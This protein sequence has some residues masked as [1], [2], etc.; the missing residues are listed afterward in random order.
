MYYKQGGFCGRRQNINKGGAGGD[1]VRWANV[2]NTKKVKL[3]NW[4]A[5][6]KRPGKKEE[7]S[8]T[9]SL[10]AYDFK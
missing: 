5:Y 6:S 3:I 7:V 8:T 4:N 9:F 1:G 2:S 10:Q